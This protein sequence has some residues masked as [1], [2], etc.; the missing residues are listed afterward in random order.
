[1]AQFN[2]CFSKAADRDLDNLYTEGFLKWGERQADDY[3]DGLIQQFDRICRNP[4]MYQSV[5]D[6][7]PGYRRCVYEKHVIYYTIKQDMIIIAAITKYQD[8]YARL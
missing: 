8:I 6:I 4:L 5:E 2:L 7:R 3:Y 1:M